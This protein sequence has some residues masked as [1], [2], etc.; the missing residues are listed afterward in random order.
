M[1]PIRT[2]TI[3]G[4][5]FWEIRLERRELFASLI[6]A[7]CVLLLSLPQFGAPLFWLMGMSLMIVAGYATAFSA[8]MLLPLAVVV[9]FPD[10]FAVKP[11]DLVFLGFILRVIRRSSIPKPRSF[12]WLLLFLPFL[13]WLVIL[14]GSQVI[15]PTGANMTAIY[16]VVITFFLCHEFNNNHFKPTLAVSLGCLCVGLPYWGSLLGLPIDLSDWGAEREGF[17]RLGSARL[18][19]VM[20]WPLAL[21]GIFVPATLLAVCQHMYGRKEL[22]RLTLF[23][24]LLPILIGLPVLFGTMTNGG[25]L[26]FGIVAATFTL[27]LAFMASAIVDRSRAARAWT[28]IVILITC[29]TLLFVTDAFE[30]ASRLQSLEAFFEQQSRDLGWAASR[31]HEWETA[32]TLI[33]QYP[34]LGAP[35]ELLPETAA[36]NAFLTYWSVAGLPAA[37]FFSVLFLSPSIVLFLRS[38]P[39]T[40]APL[41]IAN[42]IWLL[43][44]MALS[45]SFFKPVWIIWGITAYAAS[46]HSRSRGLV[47]A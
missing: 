13:V 32:W 21:I 11:A 18:D 27:W 41:V 38:G 23:Y 42:L 44:L 10:G 36:H 45:F 43:F 28:L 25:I 5:G 22:R 31:T 8:I 6:V 3:A 33:E 17:N 19:S 37:V 9:P 2:P 7:A 1:R 40:A 16:F 24:G 26:S 35:P 20:V 39:I 15:E 14:F 4:E 46:T 30:I 47:R 34:F 12:V 29:T